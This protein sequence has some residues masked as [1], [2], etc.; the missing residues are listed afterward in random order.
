MHTRTHSVV[1]SPANSNDTFPSEFVTVRRDFD[2]APYDKVARIVGRRD[3]GTYN[4][5]YLDGQTP[6]ELGVTVDRMKPYSGPDPGQSTPFPALT[7][8]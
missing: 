2:G 4:V 3:N 1:G 5:T 7:G 8:K 6:S